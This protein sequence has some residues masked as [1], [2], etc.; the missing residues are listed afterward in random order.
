MSIVYIGIGSNLG[1]R[2]ENCERAVALL[3]TNGIKVLKR[4]SLY[5]TE[6]WGI[7]EQPEFMN[8]AVE[9]ETGLEPERLL[10]VLTDIETTVGRKES[11]RWGPR[12]IDLDI[13]FYNDLILKSS[14]L[15]IPHPGIKDREFVLK[16]L[17]E[18]APYKRHP[19]FKKSIKQLLED[20]YNIT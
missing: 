8:M 17:S 9:A 16:P 11:K 7:E 3:G 12:I 20:L 10:E 19:I 15:E 5:E 4:S 2:E 6:P 1:N 13:I 18:I 14:D